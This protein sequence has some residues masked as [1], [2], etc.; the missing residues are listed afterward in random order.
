LSTI[1]A[2]TE[3]QE[4]FKGEGHDAERPEVDAR[5]ATNQAVAARLPA[6]SVFQE[7]GVDGSWQRVLFVFDQRFGKQLEG[8][9]LWSI[10][11]NR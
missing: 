8:Q 4:D 7:V 11:A 9:R 10:L 2:A 6:V 5:V 3:K 1:S